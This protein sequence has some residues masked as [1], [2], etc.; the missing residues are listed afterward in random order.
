MT[1]SAKL[2]HL[3]AAALLAASL[4]GCAASDGTPD[5]KMGRFLVAPNKYVL[6]NCAQIAEQAKATAAR[7][8]ELEQLTAKAGPGADGQL[9]SSI[10]YRPEYLELRGNMIELRRAA[11]IKNCK[12]VP[13]MEN[14]GGRASDNVIR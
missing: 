7:E 3:V 4:V 1:A 5:D 2:R 6:Y 9:V 12:F 13:G 10:T 14:S 8:K 11:A